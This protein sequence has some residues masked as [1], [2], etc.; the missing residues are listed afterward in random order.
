MCHLQAGDSYEILSRSTEPQKIH[1]LYTPAT[2]SMRLRV[3]TLIRS[4]PSH[5][6]PQHFHFW[7]DKRARVWPSP[8]GFHS[9]TC[10]RVVE[11]FLR[12]AISFFGWGSNL[13]DTS[14]RRPGPHPSLSQTTVPLANCICRLQPFICWHDNMYVLL[15]KHFYYYH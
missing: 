14:C 6:W 11:V 13:A 3:T 10:A 8:F 5:C 9:H 1:H 7:K 2:N 12:A 4:M 15:L